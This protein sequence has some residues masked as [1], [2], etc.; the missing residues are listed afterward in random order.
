MDGNL[1]VD[2][3]S[4]LGKV[5]SLLDHAIPI[6]AMTAHAMTS[7]K[8][9]CL[10]AGMNDYLTKPLEPSTLAETL[11]RWLPSQS[12]RA[13]IAT[14]E[15]SIRNDSS[16]YGE[17]KIPVFDK[18]TMMVRLMQDEE[19]ARMIIECFLED[20]PNQMDVLRRCL[21]DGDSDGALRQAHSIKGAAANVSGEAMRQVA[22]EMEKS[23]RVGDLVNIAERLPELDFE[24]SRLKEVMEE[25]LS[26]LSLM[27][28]TDEN[29]DFG[30]R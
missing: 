5:L 28:G 2:I 8:E 1:N 27:E 30:R 4:P 12:S 23:G 3:F 18:T 7:D 17:Q 21:T 22:L 29:T 6:I 9:H 15:T 26:N 24:F 16:N 20:I 25:Q 19:L 10:Q 14:P 11:D 13:L